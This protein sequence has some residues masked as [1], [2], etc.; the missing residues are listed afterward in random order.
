M[1]ISVP[2]ARF[3]L[4]DVEATPAAE[5]VNGEEMPMTSD[6]MSVKG[7]QGPEVV[8]AGTTQRQAVCSSTG[9][10]THGLFRGRGP[11]RSLVSFSKARSAQQ[12]LASEAVSR[13]ARRRVSRSDSSP[14]EKEDPGSSEF[15]AEVQAGRL[16]R[17]PAPCLPRDAHPS[18]ATLLQEVEKGPEGFWP[19]AAACPFAGD[20]TVGTLKELSGEN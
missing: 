9:G 3:H 5:L 2:S 19:G 8:A 17:P 1:A 10:G 20:G 12:R 16:A 11:G 18:T 6:T 14:R 15:V 7:G 13:A 4:F